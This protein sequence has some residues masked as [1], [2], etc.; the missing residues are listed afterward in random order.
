MK[1]PSRLADVV[2]FGL[3]TGCGLCE[4]IGGERLPMHLNAEGCLRPIVPP[5]LEPDLESAVLSVCPGIHQHG[6]RQRRASALW[7]PHK[8]VFLGH[9]TDES[10]RYTATSGGVVTAAAA[11]L[12]DCGAADTVLHVSVDATAA[13]RSDACVSRSRADLLTR[14]GARYAPAAPLR[15]LHTL[16]DAGERIVVIGK[17]CDIAGVR[18]LARQDRRVDEQVIAKLS[19]L[20]AGLPWQGVTRNIIQ[21]Y[22]LAETDV[23]LLRYRGQGCPGPVRIEAHDGRVFEQTYNETWA[24]E[25]NSGVQ[26][27]CKICPDST[28]E[29]ADLVCGDAWEGGEGYP[30]GE[31][32][33]ESVII[34]RTATGKALLESLVNGGMVAAGPMATNRLRAMQP[35]HIR[36]KSQILSRLMGLALTGQPR[37][38]YRNLRLLRAG[39]HG[40]RRAF[41]NMHGMVRRVRRGNNREHLPMA[42][43]FRIAE[44]K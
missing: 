27:R 6:I 8:G 29:Q 3:C 16:L 31:S 19:F 40:L 33:G 39:L 10:L 21:K 12:L 34:A 20:C 28:G 30:L 23:R 5:D 37:P 22:G 13:T 11:Y 36:R 26:F 4:S 38:R 42:S 15:F 1:T 14:V 32:E 25:L 24:D 35:Q 18:N 43:D 44:E 2:R 17:P 9:A 41:A 7:G